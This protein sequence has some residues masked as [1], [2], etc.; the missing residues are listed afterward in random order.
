[1]NSFLRRENTLYVSRGGGRQEIV[2]KF[3]EDTRHIPVLT[4]QTFTAETGIPHKTHFTFIGDEIRTLYEFIRSL[5]LINL[6][7]ENKV[8]VTD[9]ELRRML[10]TPDQARFLINQ[11]Q[12]LILTLAKSE[13]TKADIVA[14]GYR[15]KQLERFK[16]LLTDPG[17]FDLEKRTLNLTDEAVWQHFF[18]ENKWIFG[19]GLTYL[20]LLSLDDRKLEQVAVGY[21]ID[22]P[23]KRADALM[24]TRGFINALCFI[25]IK[26]HTTELLQSDSYRSGCWA[27]SDELAG[28]V[29]QVQ[30]TTAIATKKLADKV[31]LKDSDGNLTGEEVFTYKPR[32]FLVVGNLDQFKN[33][34]GVN[35][36]K[37]RSFELLRRNTEQP[38]IITFDELYHRAKYIVEHSTD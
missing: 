11:N 32:S 10:L 9:T 14:L 26:K 30:N 2:A 22:N 5:K 33:E 34:N 15:K 4:I 21:S 35:Q 6:H 16:N 36:D 25:E 12:E 23:G 29:A 18:E 8:N 7:D 19:Y 28:G 27:P 31:E 20:F 24:K 13:V 3:Y 17:V 37:Y 38:E 1:M